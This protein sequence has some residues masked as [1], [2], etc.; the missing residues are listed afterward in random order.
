[1]C[2]WMGKGGSAG[3]PPSWE[4]NPSGVSLQFK[5]TL[6]QQIP[7]N[8]EQSRSASCQ[9]LPTSDQCFQP[10]INLPL[11]PTLA[12]HFLERDR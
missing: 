11:I 4:I 2:L 5:A 12:M 3:A 7:R 6:E 1:M 10:L 8:G 9:P